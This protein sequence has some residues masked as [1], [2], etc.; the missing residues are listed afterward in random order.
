MSTDTDSGL[1]AGSGARADPATGASPVGQDIPLSVVIVVFAGGGRLE[2]C[3]EALERQADRAALEIIVPHDASLVGVTSLRARFPQARFLALEGECPPA[4]LRARGVEHAS[5]RII[6]LLEDH[7]LPEPAWSARVLVA[8]EQQVA[9]VGGC[10]EKG[11]SHEGERDSALDWALYIADYARYMSPL[12]HGP[13]HTISDCNASYKRA[14]LE[15]VRGAWATEFHENVVNDAIRARSGTL[16]LDASIVVQEQRTL[17]WAAALRD[18]YAFGRL[19]GATRVAGSTL[20]RRFVL[21]AS[22]VALPPLLA[23]RAAKHLVVKRRHI[24]Q[25]PRSLPA[26][27]VL[28]TAWA[29]GEL[30]GYLTVTPEMSLR[31]RRTTSPEIARGSAT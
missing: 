31:S 16:V 7:C 26:L 28:S 6:A 18:R 25:L 19:Y 24:E 23:A 14:E 13:A 20:G 1:G 3:L 22:C 29:L 10:V 8:H 17:T 11:E 15:A 27:I 21:A 30:M 4:E 2:R 9:A 5:G 12:P